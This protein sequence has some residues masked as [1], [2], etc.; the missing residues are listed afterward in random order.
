MKDK[1]MNK[2]RFEYGLMKGEKVVEDYNCKIV[3]CFFR[4]PNNHYSQIM[5]CQLP[6]C[7]SNLISLIAKSEQFNYLV[8]LGT[9]H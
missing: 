2:I 9:G 6:L 7:L 1:M 3:R 5:Q 8:V 4:R